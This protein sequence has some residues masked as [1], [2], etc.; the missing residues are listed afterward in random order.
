MTF[1]TLYFTDLGYVCAKQAMGDWMKWFGKYAGKAVQNTTFM[2]GALS[3]HVI[4]G[5]ALTAADISKGGK[6]M[7]RANETMY[8][9]EQG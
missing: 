5:K 8:F 6:A 3:Y 7:T 4:P 1:L 9:W 2:H